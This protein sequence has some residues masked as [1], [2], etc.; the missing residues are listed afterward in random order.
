MFYRFIF[1][2]GPK[3]LPDFRMRAGVDRP[4]IRTI[5]KGKNR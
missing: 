3:P 4:E 5:S 1:S 2:A